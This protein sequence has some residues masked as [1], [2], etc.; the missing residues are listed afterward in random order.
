MIRSDPLTP[1]RWPG[2]AAV[3]LLVPVL[4]AADDQGRE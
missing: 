2:L 1:G 3:V 4:A